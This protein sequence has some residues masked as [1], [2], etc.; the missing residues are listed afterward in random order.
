MTWCNRERGLG[1]ACA[2]VGFLVGCSGASFST[3]DDDGGSAGMAVAGGSGGTGGT[4]GGGQ[5]GAGKGGKGGTGGNAGRGASGGSAAMGGASG[6]ASGGAGTGGAG[7]TTGGSSSGGDSGTGGDA[8][9]G[10]TAGTSGMGG[11]GGMTAC[12]TGGACVEE[13]DTCSEGGCCPC[14]LTCEGGE[15]SQ[16]LCPPCIA[17]SC[18]NSPP[19]D[20]EPCSPCSVPGPCAVDSCELENKK[21][22]F[23]CV[24]D[25]WEVTVHGCGMPACCD[26]DE[27][28]A[29]N[30]CVNTICKS[31][32]S[33]YCWRDQD[34]TN[35]D[36]CSGVVVC[37]CTAD[38][39]G[40]DVPGTCV[41]D[42]QGC[43]RTDLDCADGEACIAG[44][45]KA[46]ATPGCWSDR[47]CGSG[48]CD[49]ENICSCGTACVIAD[50]PG[51]CL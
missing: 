24:D 8:G 48:T 16:P 47:D 7:G 1:S 13:G 23:E 18:P 29:S 32:A 50:S 30:I 11:S 34:C 42:G 20:G 26:S 41:P 21:Y 39:E 36:L 49:G 10:G 44:I 25:T 19:T 45:C 2:L 51:I 4:G 15:W 33:G 27:A 40:R 28:C 43:C 31:E 46:P 14:Q 35:G 12:I 38:C 3:K 6:S 9:T 37:P 22:E 17:P 5:G